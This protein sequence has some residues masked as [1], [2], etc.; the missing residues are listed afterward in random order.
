M[1]HGSGKCII[2]CAPSGAGKTTIVK[3]LLKTFPELCFSVSATSRDPRPD[4]RHGRDYYFMTADEFRT[5]IDLGAFLEWEEVYN[6]RFYGTLQKEIQRIWSENKHVIF[7]VDVVGGVNLK[8]YFAAKA[9]SIFVRPP[10]LEVLEE[11]LRNRRTESD[12]GLKD[13]LTKASYELTFANKFDRVL[14]NDTLPEACAQAEE[15]VGKFLA[16]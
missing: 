11:R 8:S 1:P 14:I 12:A 10:S 4:E 5:S 3:H 9:L 2:V 16:S 7:D 15:W 13:R 6:G